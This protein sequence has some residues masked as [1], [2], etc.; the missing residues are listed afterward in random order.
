MIA[1]HLNGKE[2]KLSRDDADRL[3]I[4]GDNLNHLWLGPFGSVICL[5]PKTSPKL[6]HFEAHNER[7][8]SFFSMTYEVTPDRL[9]IATK[10]GATYLLFK[11]DLKR[12]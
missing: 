10:N 11:R 4:V 5:E 6:M 9:K 12:P 3:V 8:S 1:V 7:R 2:Q